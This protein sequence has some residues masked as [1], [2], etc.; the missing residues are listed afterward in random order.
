M[1]VFID[2][3]NNNDNKPEMEYS[4]YECSLLDRL[5]Q[6]AHA[7]KAKLEEL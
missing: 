2:N 1:D 5:Q 3:D 6:W 7:Q 4:E